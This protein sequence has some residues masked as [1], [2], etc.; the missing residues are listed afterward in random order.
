MLA[1]VL[2][3]QPLSPNDQGLPEGPAPRREV[4][5][6]DH[7]Q[8]HVG[9][10]AYFDG[11]AG[12]GL[13]IGGLHV[14]PLEGVAL[15]HIDPAAVVGADHPADLPCRQRQGQVPAGQS[16]QRPALR[17]PHPPQVQTK[18]RPQAGV[19]ADFLGKLGMVKAPG[20]EFDRL[21]LVLR[22]FVGDAV[23]LTGQGVGLP[24]AQ[25]FQP[26][27]DR[28]GGVAEL[29]AVGAD[30][31]HH[32]LLETPFRGHEAPDPFKMARDPCRKLFVERVM[33]HDQD[34]DAARL[35]Q[36]VGA[37]VK[38]LFQPSPALGL[39]VAGGGLVA[40]QIAVRR[41][42]P[43][44][45]EAAEADGGLLEIPVDDFVQQRLRMPGPVPVEF[46]AISLD[47]VGTQVVL[48]FRQR[49]PFPG[50]RVDDAHRT[51]GAGLQQGQYPPRGVRVGRVVAVGRNY[52]AS[53]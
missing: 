13:L 24:G 10:R 52:L 27:A 36:P 48:A 15:D 37:L 4:Q 14:L 22:Y 35:Q 1:I 46:H 20:G 16:A 23:P 26:C 5:G 30:A 42:Q 33:R 6:A 40:D 8:E 41:V 7:R 44:Q 17:L 38:Q 25:A 28:L 49:H 43:E 9:R 34:H 29:P 19:A 39:L 12:P 31:H 3:K 18:L 2:Q 21:P 51:L 45:A 11:M 32:G 50:A 53:R 47:V